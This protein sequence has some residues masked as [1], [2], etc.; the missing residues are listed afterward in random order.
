MK[1]SQ[2]GERGLLHR[3]ERW[4]QKKKHSSN[5]SKLVPLGDDCF[6]AKMATNDPLVFSTDTLLEGTHFNLKWLG[7]ILPPPKVWDSL[8][9]KAMSSNLSDLASMGEVTPHFA[10]VTLG[11]S[12]DIS[13]DSVDNLY[14]GM[15]RLGHKHGIYIVG[16]DIIRS[17]KSTISLTLVGSMM[18][19]A[20]PL[21]RSGAKVG[22]FLFLTAPT[23]LSEAGLL[24]LKTGL[25]HFKSSH[26]K[27]LLW[28]HL[29]PEPKIKEGSLIGDNLATS[30]IDTSDDLLTSL[31]ILSQKSKVGFELQLNRSH[32]PPSLLYGSKLLHKDPLQLFLSGGED[33]QLLF[34]CPKEKLGTLR[35][36]IPSALQIGIVRSPSHGIQIYWKGRPFQ[37]KESRFKHF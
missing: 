16:G 25:S 29:T 31:E 36:K 28:S 10:F 5:F 12:G 20:T 34:T 21:T 9:Y 13:V 7:S 30:C 19:G 24:L 6:V 27:K 3:I 32:I 14:K 33:Y 18:L 11:L 8:G 26:I 37:I 15:N 22:D 1:L 17:D 23:G 2:I 35:K 4:T